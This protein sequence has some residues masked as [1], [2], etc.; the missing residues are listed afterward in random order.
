MDLSLGLANAAQ[1]SIVCMAMR[2]FVESAENGE[3]VV[4]M[5]TRRDRRTGEWPV[6]MHQQFPNNY[7]S[8]TGSMALGG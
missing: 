8:I 5:F 6:R 1:I 7:C 4:R 3:N 2:E